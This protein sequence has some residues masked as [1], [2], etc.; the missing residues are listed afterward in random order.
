MSA[1]R[2]AL[3]FWVMG[4]VI[5]CACFLAG[6]TAGLDHH[7]DRGTWFIALAIWFV[8]TSFPKRP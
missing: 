4:N 3:A 7:Y 5:A 2:T 8:P 6:F 1:Y